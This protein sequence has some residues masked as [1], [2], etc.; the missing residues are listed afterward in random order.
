MATRKVPCKSGG[1]KR[2]EN[3]PATERLWH[4]F[5]TDKPPYLSVDKFRGEWQFAVWGQSQIEV[6]NNLADLQ[7]RLRAAGP[8]AAQRIDMPA[9]PAR[10]LQR[11]DAYECPQCIKRWGVCEAC[12]GLYDLT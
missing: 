7:Q 9:R 2:V 6:R 5:K 11:G 1:F 4:V 10:K 12:E 8:P 3:V